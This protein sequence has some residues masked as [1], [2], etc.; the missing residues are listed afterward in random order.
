LC[1][2]TRRCLR[3]GQDGGGRRSGALF[4]ARA[5]ALDRRLGRDRRH[6]QHRL[7]SAVLYVFRSG[8]PASVLVPVACAQAHVGWS[9]PRVWQGHKRLCAIMAKWLPTDLL[10]LLTSRPGSSRRTTQVQCLSTLMVLSISSNPEV[11]NSERLHQKSLSVPPGHRSERRCGFG[12]ATRALASSSAGPLTQ[13]WHLIPDHRWQP[14]GRPDGG[15][16]VSSEVWRTSNPGE[17]RRSRGQV[18]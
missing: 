12:S 2:R 18:R 3:C 15:L 5:G 6:P 14:I 7:P 16:G 17:P 4:G 1:E 8:T 11:R 10:R 9:S 13:C